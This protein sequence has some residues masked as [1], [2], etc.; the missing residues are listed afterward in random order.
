MIEG[1]LK[2]L[3]AALMI[4]AIVIHGEVVKA[5]AGPLYSALLGEA[6]EH[7]STTEQGTL[8]QFVLADFCTLTNRLIIIEECIKT[9][10]K[11]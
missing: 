7:A 3:A 8:H 1:N 4:G 6:D 10:S 2:E 11:I 5:M 9:V